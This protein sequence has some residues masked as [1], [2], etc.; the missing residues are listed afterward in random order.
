[1]G[2]VDVIHAFVGMFERLSVT[3]ISTHVPTL[4]IQNIRRGPLE[5][6]RPDLRESYRPQLY[7]HQTLA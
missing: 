1:M 2:V 4:G 5:E 7:G 6:V 3:A